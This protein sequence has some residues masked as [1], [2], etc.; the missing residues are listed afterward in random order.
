MNNKNLKHIFN[1]FYFHDSHIENIEI[2]SK[3]VNERK[4]IIILNYYNWEENTSKSSKWKWKKMKIIF[5]FLS[6]IEWN[7]PD[8]LHNK[9]EIVDVEFDI[10]IKK[11]LKIENN[12]KQEFK[13][14]KSPLFD[15]DNGYLSI[16][17]NI[18]NYGESLTTD[19]GYILL[20]GSDVKYEWINDEN[21]EGKIHI[22]ADP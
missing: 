9:I 10:N 13:N 3:N 17:F 5:N 21:L 4:C 20:I 19:S 7:I 14:Y 15:N 2:I 16:K 11:L 22:S 18:C 1:Q 6:N 12:K 8:F